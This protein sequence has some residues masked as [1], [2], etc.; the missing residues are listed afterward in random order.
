MNSQ[1]LRKDGNVSKFLDELVAKH[2]RNTQLSN[3]KLKRISKR[4]ANYISLSNGLVGMDAI[5]KLKTENQMRDRVRFQ[6][7]P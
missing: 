7:N 4:N 3:K 1:A 5:H 2:T 6:P